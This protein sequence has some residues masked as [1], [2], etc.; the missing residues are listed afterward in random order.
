MA[1]H[2]GTKCAETF[3][4][5]RIMVATRQVPSNVL[6]VNGLRPIAL[7][8]GPL[9]KEEAFKPSDENPEPVSN[10]FWARKLKGR[11]SIAPSSIFTN[12]Q[13]KKHS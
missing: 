6:D 7:P 3:E 4:W 5:V 11:V 13:R 12:P 10:T 8:K 1:Y 2:D 9:T